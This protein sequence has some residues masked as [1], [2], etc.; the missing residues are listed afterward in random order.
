MKLKTIMN[1]TLRIFSI[2]V[3]LKSIGNL[4]ATIP[5]I[6]LSFNVTDYPVENIYANAI[7][8]LVLAFT[9]VMLIVFSD[10][11]IIFIGNGFDFEEKIDSLNVN[12]VSIAAYSVIGIILITFSL[13][14]LISESISYKTRFYSPSKVDSDYLSNKSIIIKEFVSVALGVILICFRKKLP[15]IENNSK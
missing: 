14:D 9:G 13:P 12:G 3:I 1:V 11:I 6:M 4:I 5:L 8:A 7:Y 2:W 10:K 15:P